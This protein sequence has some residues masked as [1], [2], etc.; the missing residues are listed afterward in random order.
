MAE[1]RNTGLARAPEP[2][3]T[4]TDA[5]KE[6]LQR[7]M[8][9]ARESITQ[10]VAEIKETVAT[11]YQSVRESISDSLDWRE[12]YRR[13]PAA[14]SAGALGVGLLLGYS[15]GGALRGGRDDDDDFDTEDEDVR[16]SINASNMSAFTPAHAYAAQPITGGQHG[17]SNLDDRATSSA[18]ATPYPAGPFG[19]SAARTDVGPDSRQG[20]GS[21]SIGSAPVAYSDEPERPG[22]FQRV[23]ESG[24]IDK[25]KETKVYDRLQDELSS[26][27]DRFVEELSTTARNVVVPA[28]LGKLKDLIGIDLSTQKEVA[29]RSQLE[30]QTATART[31]AEDAAEGTKTGGA[32]GS[33]SYGTSQNRV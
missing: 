32:A 15:V 33:D 2:Q 18:S 19:T 22:I 23:K 24:V 25:F 27:G 31:A 4:D 29:Q 9:E 13:R 30:H 7:R 3:T 5:T 20:Y 16:A 11:Q 12:Q 26:L 10:T 21:Q 14:F 17:V 8:E 6:Q 28:L 1:E